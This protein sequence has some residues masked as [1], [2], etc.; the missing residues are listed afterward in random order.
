MHGVYKLTLTAYDYCGN[1]SKSVE[2]DLT[3]DHKEPEIRVTPE[4]GNGAKGSKWYFNADK[5]Q[6]IEI[7]FSDSNLKEEECNVTLKGPDGEKVACLNNQDV[8]TNIFNV[9]SSNH[10]V[11]ISEEALKGLTEGEYTLSF[12]A[13]DMA[14]NVSSSAALSK[15]DTGSDEESG[16]ESE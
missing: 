5:G 12:K 1:E 10:T 14:G 4:N 11:T 3:F 15:S 16:S 6:Q 2:M 9:D 7:S 13:E 8:D